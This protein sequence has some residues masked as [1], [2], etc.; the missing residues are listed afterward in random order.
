MNNI[1]FH[2]PSYFRCL[3]LLLL[4]CLF[5]F[6][7]NKRFLTSKYFLVSNACGLSVYNLFNIDMKCN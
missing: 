2:F 3:Y 6:G 5:V 7:Y 1:L 4:N